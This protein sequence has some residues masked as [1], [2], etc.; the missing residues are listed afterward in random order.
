[1]TQQTL[2]NAAMLYEKKTTL[3]I[4]DLEEVPVN[5]DVEN[6][7]YKEGTPEEFSILVAKVGDHEYR[8]PSSVLAQLQALLLDKRTKTMKKFKVLKTGHTMNDTKYTVIPLGV[9]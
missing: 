8:V 3:N 4:A 7:T 1:M 6:K 9:A 2:D 5:V